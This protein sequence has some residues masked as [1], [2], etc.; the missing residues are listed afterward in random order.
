MRA[1]DTVNARVYI[2]TNPPLSANDKRSPPASHEDRT[3]RE[4][5]A[6]APRRTGQGPA[7]VGKRSSARGLGAP[8]IAAGLQTTANNFKNIS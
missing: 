2:I 7:L 4:I 6:A 1:I 8:G 3:A 5:P